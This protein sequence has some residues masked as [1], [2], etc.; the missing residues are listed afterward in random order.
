MDA[1]GELIAAAVLAQQLERERL[2]TQAAERELAK[3]RQE[4]IRIS[5]TLTARVDELEDERALTLHLASTDGLTG[6]LNR[7]AFAAALIERLE[8]AQAAGASVALLVIDLD[9][10]KTLNDSLGHHAGDQLLIE[11]GLR[12]RSTALPGD[13]ACRLGGDE[14]CLL[15]QAGS[16]EDVQRV[17]TRVLDATRA[18]LSLPQHP[19][20]ICPVSVG[21]C[22]VD[23]GHDW[24]DWYAQADEALYL[25]KR[26]GGNRAQWR[27]VAASART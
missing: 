25:A 17:A 19:P 16:L 8:A 10:F 2:A 7:G 11:I 3:A 12:L 1:P 21:A 14:F 15:V 18:Q 20:R 24:G 26:Q 13:V 4:L 27:E 23:A 6:L 22:L 5:Q 9:R